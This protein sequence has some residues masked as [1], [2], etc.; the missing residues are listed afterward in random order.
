MDDRQKLKD[1][2]GNLVTGRQGWKLP[3]TYTNL[4]EA[5]LALESSSKFQPMKGGKALDASGRP[6]QLGLWINRGRN[7]LYRPSI[8]DLDRY[9]STWW[10]WWARLQPEWRN[11]DTPSGTTA[12]QLPREDGVW[13]GLDKPGING[14]VSVVVSLKWWAAETSDAYTDP[15]WTAAVDD[16][17][18]VMNSIAKSRSQ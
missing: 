1:G 10:G 8:A 13:S 14:F 18:W 12:I 11:I 17:C 4:V 15:R 2:K 3:N 5:C 16:V 6:E 7:P 9:A